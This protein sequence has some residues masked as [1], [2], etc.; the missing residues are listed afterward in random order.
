MN[1]KALLLRNHI[2]L[3]IDL[4]VTAQTLFICYLVKYV[5]ANTPVP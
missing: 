4:T 3:I 1:S 5:V 2:K